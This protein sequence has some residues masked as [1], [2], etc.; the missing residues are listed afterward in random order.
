M[1]RARNYDTHTKQDH[2]S[3]NIY[4][5]SNLVFGVHAEAAHI[6]RRRD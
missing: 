5:N 6:K 1:F 3:E 2:S 4:N